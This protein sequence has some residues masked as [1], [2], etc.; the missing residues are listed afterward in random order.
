MHDEELLEAI[1]KKR[2]AMLGGGRVNVQKTAEIVLTDFRTATLGRVTL[3]LPQEFDAWSAA[4]AV[5][6]AERAA[7][8]EA[9]KGSK[10]NKGGK[11]KQDGTEKPD[12]AAPSVA[13]RGDAAPAPK[14]P[15]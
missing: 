10:G 11:G 14:A 1:G 3:E 6:E 5:H 15:R 7:R 2:G 8:L 4:A 12:A 13:P 9:R